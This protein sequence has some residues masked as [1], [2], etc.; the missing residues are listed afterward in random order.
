MFT[1]LISYFTNQVYVTQTWALPL[2]NS[3]L[4][5]LLL[6]LGDEFPAD[7]SRQETFLDAHQLRYSLHRRRQLLPL[8]EELVPVYGGP[9]CV[10]GRDLRG[11]C[12]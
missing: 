11:I 9:L 1:A 3:H 7:R 4:P 5:P 10:Q 2:V 8:A 12:T 6:R